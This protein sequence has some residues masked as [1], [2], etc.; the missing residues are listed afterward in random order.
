VSGDLSTGPGLPTPGHAEFEELAVGHALDAL[1]PFDEARL[2]EHLPSCSRCRLALG[3]HREVA[4]WLAYA[5]DPVEEPALPPLLAEVIAAT[6]STMPADPFALHSPVPSAAQ[7][8]DD[9]ADS[10]DS[11]DSADGASAAAADERDVPAG[12]VTPARRPAGRMRIALVGGHRPSRL[13]A[14]AALALAVLLTGVVVGVRASNPSTVTQNADP[15]QLALEA[16]AQPGAVI[17]KL[18]HTDG[19][20]G[21]GAAVLAAGHTVLVVDGLAPNQPAKAHYVVWLVTGADTKRALRSFDVHASGAVPVDLGRASTMEE[22][23]TPRFAVTL[24]R[25][26]ATAV[27]PTVPGEGVLLPSPALPS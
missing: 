26:P 15:A 17:S 20:A 12:H 4:A 7:P 2:L 24:E 18:G 19:H 6:A 22:A 13:L 5:V 27:L 23:G 21:S 1:E 14:G 3:E 16:V 11:D 25:G 9:T 8:R 10:A